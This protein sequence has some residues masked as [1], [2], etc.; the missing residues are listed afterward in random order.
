MSPGGD[1]GDLGGGGSGGTGGAGASGGTAPPMSSYEQELIDA[2]RRSEKRAEQDK[3][4]ALAQVGLELMASGK[5]TIGDALGAAAA[6][7][8]GA[9][10]EARDTAENERLGLKKGLYELQ[11]QRAAALASQQRAGTRAAGSGAPSLSDLNSALNMLTTEITVYDEDGNERK[12]FVAI[13]PADQPMVDQLKE[14]RS[15]MI[16]GRFS[17]TM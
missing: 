3:W 4:L 15:A 7:G 14:Q 2:L 11:S 13:D 17:P 12:D 1:G 8:L 6:K 16:A 10:R 5:P 9:Y